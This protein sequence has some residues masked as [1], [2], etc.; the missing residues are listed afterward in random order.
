[1]LCA[2]LGL[3]GPLFFT[4][5]LNSHPCFEPVCTVHFADIYKYVFGNIRRRSRELSSS[6]YPELSSCNVQWQTSHWQQSAR[7]YAFQFKKNFN[8]QHHHHF[9]LNNQPDALIIPILFCYKTLNIS[10]IISAHHQEFST[11]HS[12][13]ANSMQVSDDCIQAVRMELQFHPD[14]AWKRSSEICMKFASAECTAEN[15]WWW[16]EMISETCRFL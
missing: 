12:A 4:G 14:S 3:L 7:K 15:S 5:T 11:V 16:A 10:G 2:Q 8:I 1:M 6:Q 9:F 13:L